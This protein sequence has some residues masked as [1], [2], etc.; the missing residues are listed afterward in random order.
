M[1]KQKEIP[2]IGI[3][4]Y[5]L[6]EADLAEEMAWERELNG[7]NFWHWLGWKA[8]IAV[9]QVL[10]LLGL[11]VYSGPLLR[12][13]DPSAAAL[14]IGVLSAVLLAILMVDAFVVSAW[15]LLRMVRPTLTE[16]YEW[17]DEH[18]YLKKGITSCLEAK[19]LTGIFSGLVL[20]CCAVFLVLL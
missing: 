1:Q 14:D 16:F 11:F 20:L 6:S 3:N 13:I 7:F 2:V 10:I 15:L 18:D 17:D 9:G 8:L 4:G 5:P 19:I 12:L